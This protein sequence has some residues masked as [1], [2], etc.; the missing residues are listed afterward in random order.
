MKVGVVG[1]GAVG[2]ATALSLIERGG[3][4]RELVVLDRVRERA[5][6][7]A[8][9]MRYATPLSPTVDVRA[10]DYDALT[11]AA[12]VI[13]TAGVN[14]KAGGA[15]DRSDP[16]GRRRLLDTNAEVYADVVPK[17]VAVA[18]EAVLMVVTD[19]PDPLADLTRRLAGHDRVFSTGTLIDSLRFRVHLADRVRVRPRDVQA[20]V[21]GEHGTSEVL[22]WSSASVSGI[23][24]LD[25]LRQD[26]QPL[27]E[28]KEQ[29][30]NDIR[31]ANITIIEGTGASQ[32]GIGAV[33]ARLAE[34]VLRDERAVLPVAAY[35]PAHDVTLS[36]VS[37]LGA[38]GVQQMYEPAMSGEEREA[39]ERSAAVL[40][41]AAGR[42][43][44]GHP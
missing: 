5:D 28:L 12:L 1:A 2:A 14:E 22:L 42:V 18:P 19:P 39:L 30:E 44:S 24:V 33:S 26:S 25:L 16:D 4:C 6:G 43:L 34:A 3:M 15:T 21:V 40:R 10:G 29:I 9:D 32:Y 8:V 7:V 17:V 11:G 35:S 38:G 41:E 36:L 31:Y 20:M 23:P 13:I 27:E 37:V